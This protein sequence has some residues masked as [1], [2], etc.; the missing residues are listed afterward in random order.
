[1]KR[2]RK[3]LFR[4][5]LSYFLTIVVLFT[6]IALARGPA[7]AQTGGQSGGGKREYTY[8]DT[9]YGTKGT[10][11]DYVDGKG[12]VYKSIWYDN[13][14][15][16]M[17]KETTTYGIGEQ[18][19]VNTFIYNRT[20][21]GGK[22]LATLKH[23]K[24]DSKGNEIYNE[25]KIF[26]KN[27][28]RIGGSRFEVDANGEKR[29]YTWDPQKK[30]YVEVTEG[31]T[32]TNSAVSS[33]ASPGFA[34]ASDVTGGLNTTTFDTP[35]G[36]IYVNL[37]DNI[38]AGDTISGTVVAEAEG[39]DDKTRTQNQGELSGYVVQIEKQQ[40][41]STDRILKLFIPAAISITYLVLRDKK[42]KEVARCELPVASQQL[43]QL[44][45]QEFGLPT[46]GQQGRPVE[47][48][49]TFDGDFKTTTLTV[50]G[51]RMEILAE[52]PRQL[53]VRNGNILIGPTQLVVSEQGRTATGEFRSIGIRLSAPKLDLLRGEQTTLT[54]TVLGLEG[55]KAPVP[56]VLEN[57]SPGIISMGSAN[58]E[59]ISISPS[60]VQGGTYTTQRPLTGIQRGAFTITGTVTSDRQ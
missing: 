36:K 37:P 8:D 59:R 9:R 7:L 5:L 51:E 6:N 29:R 24:T 15:R 16:E 52:S 13:K 55:I 50:G 10:R 1:M 19:T 31:G 4:V 17:E 25:V 41:S 57:K 49:G 40:S 46:M 27:Q 12:R 35:R 42:G 22:Q 30:D 45:A 47:V 18:K 2:Y 48:T 43:T 56:L 14:V 33:S 20:D 26:D 32:R 54:V 53:V 39:Q 11:I 28:N 58:F 44:P 23:L 60:Q 21:D 3:N 34:V 38:S